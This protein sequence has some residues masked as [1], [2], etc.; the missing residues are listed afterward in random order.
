MPPKK[1]GWGGNGKGKTT[2]V[3]TT[4]TAFSPVATSAAAG[5]TPNGV[6]AANTPMMVGSNA[7]SSNTRIQRAV[8]A[9]GR[10]G[11]F[12]V[13]NT[14]QFFFAVGISF[15]VY[16]QFGW[17]YALIVALVVLLRY[18]LKLIGYTVRWVVSTADGAAYTEALRRA[19]IMR[20][21]V[22]AKECEDGENSKL[23]YG[24]SSMQGWRRSMEDAHTMKLL[25]DGGMF[26][27][28]DGHSGA[29]TAVYCGNNLYDFVVRTK[30]YS[31]GDIAT[32]LY[33]G[34]VGIDRHLY[35][36]PNF[37]RSGCTA[38]VLYVKDDQL[39]CANAGDSRCVLCRDGE[40]FPLS[41]DHKPFLTTE[42]TRIER[43]GGY[44]WNRRVNGILA[45][46]RAIGDFG[47]KGNAQV[48][49]VQQAVTSAPE[50]RST[51]INRDRDEFAV[52]ACDG[53]WDVLNSDQVVEF[54]RPK[55]QQRMPLSQIAGLLM[56]KC[57]SPMPFGFGC[58]N[59]SVIIVEFK[60]NHP[61][62]AADGKRNRTSPLNASTTSTQHGLGGA[63]A[64]SSD[65][66]EDSET[67]AVS[68]E[69]HGAGVSGASH[70][71]D[72]TEITV[73][74]HGDNAAATLSATPPPPATG[75][76]RSLESPDRSLLDRKRHRSH[77]TSRLHGHSNNGNGSSRDSSPENPSLDD[78]EKDE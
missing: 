73:D 75:R 57:L 48:S 12:S 39:F 52:I 19:D 27:V 55:I 54:V 33:D 30:A 60:R 62:P 74:N 63:S 34:F 11:V 51:Q 6:G 8:R 14:A 58:D 47:F 41:V 68:F 36:L 77:N 15:V 40:A 1:F 10:R 69:C 78:A 49:W 2:T 7:D 59:M 24:Y 17:V 16:R 18:I 43:A 22:V 70:T 5:G 46:S 13:K 28:F 20:E 23:R 37:E 3:A 29:A 31:Q 65:A 25:D 44:V 35:S 42:Q 71:S 72:T 76:S 26:G 38:V 9:V 4:T 66:H 32:A 53:I 56:D 67:A 64:G 45:L 50:V 61:T 21:P